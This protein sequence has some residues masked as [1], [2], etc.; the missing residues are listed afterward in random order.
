MVVWLPS[1]QLGGPGRCTR[2]SIPCA[3]SSCCVSLKPSST[4]CGAIIRKPGTVRSL[5][6]IPEH[7]NKD[8]RSGRCAGVISRRTLAAAPVCAETLRTGSPAGAARQPPEGSRGAGPPAELRRERDC[9]ALSEPPTRA[10]PHT[11][12]RSQRVRQRQGCY[13]LMLRNDRDTP[14]SNTEPQAGLR[15][16]AKA[17]PQ[18]WQSLQP[19]GS[20]SPSQRALATSLP[21]M[22]APRSP[23]PW[24]P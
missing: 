17:P 1:S 23:H 10:V 11:N 22:T 19:S 18:H 21:R 7:R 6:C 12:S 3:R 2:S 15:S 4:N 16:P 9:G 8:Q 24:D 5:L 20:P 13:L 14:S